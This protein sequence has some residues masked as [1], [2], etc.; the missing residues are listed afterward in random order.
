MIDTIEDF[1][2]EI[3][4]SRDDFIIVEGDYDVKIFGEIRQNLKQIYQNDYEK[5]SKLAKIAIEFPILSGAGKGQRAMVE[6]VCQEAQ[7][8]SFQN[9]LVGFCDREFDE[10][11]TA[12]N[13][14]VDN[15]NGQLEANEIVFS[16]GHSIENYFLENEIFENTIRTLVDF[17]E[18]VFE[19]LQSIFPSIFKFATSLSLVFHRSEELSV[20]KASKRLNH[21]CSEY[22]FSCLSYDE[23]KFAF[24]AV[25]WFEQWG[26]YPELL[27]EFAKSYQSELELCS[28][29]DADTLVQCCHGKLGESF[30]WWATNALY[31]NSSDWLDIDTLEQLP[32]D[33]NL[34]KRYLH[35]IKSWNQKVEVNEI[36]IQKTPYLCF[37]KLG[38]I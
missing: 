9:Q 27:D 37:R 1:F 7:Q 16:R 26:E 22:N 33:F 19:A 11:D 21:L 35:H 15:R 17:P 24:D 13:S 34:N 4:I 10:F 20:K 36:N 25:K 8:A 12:G 29:T 5:T 6:K 31:F 32:K 28:A 38:A 14:I 23:E 30:L 2:A 18:S 3:E